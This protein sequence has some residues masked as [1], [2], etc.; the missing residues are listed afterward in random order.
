MAMGGLYRERLVF[1][2]SFH[3][4]GRDLTGVMEEYGDRL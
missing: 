2:I 4:V 3:H 1:V